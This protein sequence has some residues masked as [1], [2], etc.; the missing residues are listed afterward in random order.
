M[1]VSDFARAMSRRT[2]AAVALAAVL[3]TGTAWA[4]A[5]AGGQAAPAAG[6]A[7]A[8]DPFKFDKT[9]AGVMIFTIKPESV[10]EFDR[11]W[12][13]IKKRTAASPDE[14]LKQ[15]GA[16]LNI[17]KFGVAAPDGTTYVVTADPAS[18][19]LSYSLSPFLLF[20]S[21]LFTREEGEAILNK[22]KDSIAQLNAIAVTKIQ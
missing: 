16:S 18:K 22:I 6:A 14:G 1:M 8:E 13:E 20:E 10:A 12:G 19:T 3:G 4:Q 17:Y 7:P 15:L 5:A 21:K 9:G 2:L 11:M